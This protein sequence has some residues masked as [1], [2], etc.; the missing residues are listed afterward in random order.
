MKRLFLDIEGT[1][2]D[3][4]FNPEFLEENC[5][6]IKK[7]IIDTK[8][9]IVHLFT[10]G[11]KD[12]TEIDAFL[13]LEMFNHIGIN[14][15]IDRFGIKVVL[16]ETFVKVDSVDLCI[17]EDWIDDSIRERMLEPGMMGEFGISKQS[18]FDLMCNRLFP[19]DKCLLIDDT[20]ETD[21]ER[22]INPK[23]L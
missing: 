3:S 2:I 11:W 14:T 9:D 4:L 21:N 1:I 20:N 13:V 5:K 16:G 23:D 17:A 6:K 22:F 18:C 12:I 10:W 15:G 7:F 19:K 8:P